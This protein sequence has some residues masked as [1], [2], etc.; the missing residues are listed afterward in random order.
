MAFTNYTGNVPSALALNYTQNIPV[1][2][3]ASISGSRIDS[4][5][6]TLGMSTNAYTN[7]YSVRVRL[8]DQYG[9]TLAETSRA[10]IKFTSGNYGQAYFD[11]GFGTGFDVNAIRSIDVFGLS[12][13]SKIF[14][15]S[16]QAVGITY[17]V[18][19]ACTPPSSVTLSRA[20]AEPS[21]A[22]TLNWI[23]AGA[24][25]ANG[26]TGYI[27]Q[28]STNGAAWVDWQT[29]DASPYDVTAHATYGNYYD[30]RIIT[31]GEYI[32]SA[33]SAAI[34]LTTLTP[35]ACGSPSTVTLS[36]TT[37]DP[38]ENV[39][40]S[41]LGASAGT[42]NSIAGYIIQRKLNSGSW[43][44]W[45]SV[46]TTGTSGNY[47]VTAHPTYGNFYEY[48]IVTVGSAG[49]SYYSAASV[50]KRVTTHTPTA[51]GAPSVATLSGSIAESAPTLTYSGASGGTINGITGYEIQYSESTNN[52]IWGNWTALKTVTN[53]SASGSTTV[54][55]SATRSYY[56]KY[57]I[58]IQGAAGSSYY[59]AWKETGSCR[60]NSVPTAHTS[61]GA[62][63]AV[64]VSGAITLTYSGATDAD[65][66][67]STHNVQYAT[68]ADGVTWGG[69]ASLANG[70]TSH[71][72]TLSPGHYIK[73]QARAVDAFGITSPA[74][75]GSNVCGKNTAP[76]NATVNYPQASKTIYN[77]R[78]RILVTLGD[79]P[80]GHTQTINSEGFTP[81]QNNVSSAAKIV[82][83]K[84]DAASAGAVSFA[85]TTTDQYGESSGEVTRSTTYA[86]PSFTDAALVGGTTRIK[87]AHM[88]EL[89]EMVEDVRAYYGLGENLFSETNP[90]TLLS[91]Y[92]VTATET[93]NVCA[94]SPTG[95]CVD[96]SNITRGVGNY[97]WY[98]PLKTLVPLFGTEVKTYT[99][100]FW[101]KANNSQTLEISPNYMSWL[102]TS[103]TSIETAYSFVTVTVRVSALNADNYNFHVNLVGAGLTDVSIYGIKIECGS[104][105]TSWTNNS[106]HWGELITAG[107]TKSRNWAA[108][109][110]EMQDAVDDV[111]TLVNGWDTASTVNRIAAFA[112]IS[113]SV[114][115]SAA[116]M[117]QIRQVIAWL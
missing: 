78:P 84:S 47:T 73:Y 64:Y 51:C 105:A 41:W 38:S 5:I 56:R 37:A 85:M 15:K 18:R 20:S 93:V 26:A 66:N 1:S 43:S 101:I 45:Q 109:I 9:G 34:R 11:F 96:L 75:I 90:G 72:P 63:P 52:S 4:V 87:A 33:P 13:A 53:G 106:V 103:T 16:G 57:R 35:T 80:E 74:W 28:R 39:V 77:S 44:D 100:S 14:V 8:I 98:L 50:S 76:A 62:S 110:V 23:G 7:T 115:P 60:Y 116:V 12:D 3:G 94:E 71:T 104:V 107:V 91:L 83:R 27:I 102:N 95:T 82:L 111:V 69:W 32:N 54:A 97:V 19:T 17:T 68:S 88:T 25:D 6:A 40:L 117:N 22:A 48:K 112:W 108:H 2:G 86:A 10:D 42:I 99:I 24:G 36:K 30:Y 46:T 21:G 58:R 113:P 61:F 29:D 49:V 114:K 55:L 59:S 81:S 70:A 92:G 67:I 31:K 79:D 89:R 65:G